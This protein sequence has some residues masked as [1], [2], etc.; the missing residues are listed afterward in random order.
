MAESFP[1]VLRSALRLSPI[2]RARL[3]EEI[4]RSFE[5]NTER[6][7]AEAWAE[8]AETRIDAYERGEIEAVPYEH[9]KRSIEQ[10]DG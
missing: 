4:Y 3:I 7:A 8:E 6:Q 5:S 10:N 2:D 1:A 9:V